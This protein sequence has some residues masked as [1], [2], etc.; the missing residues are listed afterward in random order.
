MIL[1]QNW[2]GCWEMPETIVW[3]WF[4]SSIA[5]IIQPAL[6]LSVS[7]TVRVTM[8]DNHVTLVT[9]PGM[10]TPSRVTEQCWRWNSGSCSET[11]TVSTPTAA[12][13]V[14][15][16][17]SY[18]NYS[19][20]IYSNSSRV[21]KSVTG[22]RGTHWCHAWRPLSPPQRLTPFPLLHSVSDESR[23]GWTGLRAS[24]R[25][26]KCFRVSWTVTL[27]CWLNSVEM[28]IVLADK[29]A[30]FLLL[31]V[32]NAYYFQIEIKWHNDHHQQQPVP[33]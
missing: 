8:C 27:W 23:R 5:D 4:D 21:M 11:T 13:G 7:V 19:E 31:F 28:L 29:V 26:R 25:S 2:T 32:S 17:S 3:N 33:P 6:C 14:V 12:R 10:G 20:G 1:S 24:G 15:A 9:W 22:E 30:P 18:Y 16:N